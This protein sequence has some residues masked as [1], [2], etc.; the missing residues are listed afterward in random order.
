MTGFF[1]YSDTVDCSQ[2]GEPTDDPHYPHDFYCNK[3]ADCDC[4]N[5]VCPQ[6]CWEC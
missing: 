2:C 3:D 1:Y 5:P 4:D 6:H